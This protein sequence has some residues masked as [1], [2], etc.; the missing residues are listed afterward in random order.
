MHLKR[1]WP[2]LL[3]FTVLAGCAAEAPPEAGSPTYDCSRIPAAPLE[4]NEL[5]APRGSKDLAF[6][7]FGYVTG[8]DGFSLVRANLAG[9]TQV[10]TTADFGGEGPDGLEY[11][12]DG[13]LLG[14]SQNQGVFTVTP[15]G[16]INSLLP[17]LREVFGL[18]LW[19]DGMVYAG[20][21][22]NIYRIDP[23]LG[24]ATV[25][26]RGQDYPELGEFRPR[27]V[28]FTLDYS[29]MIIGTHE[30][31]LF[32]VPVD[33][34]LNPVGDPVFWLDVA[35]SFSGVDG[36]VVD[37]C[38]NFYVPSYPDELYRITPDGVAHLYH[39]WAG[40]EAFG[41]GV[42]WGTG[43]D[44]WREDALYLPRPYGGYTVVEVVTGVPGRRQMPEPQRGDA[45]LLSC[46]T[47]SPGSRAGAPGSQPAKTTLMLLTITLFLHL[48]TRARRRGRPGGSP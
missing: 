4:I 7:A 3:F 28:N 16:A 36:L 30:N 2:C 13:R 17:D 14:A 46:R 26:L 11:L 15:D 38:G 33:P 31:Q 42:R 39:K 5:A 6:D 19:P 24:T 37:V 48:R 20:D 35:G 21:N 23:R 22:A 40:V 44:G 34:A 41:H 27:I 32:R 9:D 8:F 10:L 47:G 18:L 29:T 25:L 45:H 1:I 12:P 43:R